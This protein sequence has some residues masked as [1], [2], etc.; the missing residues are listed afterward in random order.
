MAITPNT[1]LK[2]IKSK[3]AIDNVNQLTFPNKQA[4]YNYFNSLP[5]ISIE[6][7]EV[8]YQRKDNV[9]HFPGHIDTL[10]EYNYCMYQNENYEN[11]WFYAYIVRMEYINDG[12]TDIYLSTDVWQTWQFDLVFKES[13]VEREMINVNED[14]AGANLINEDIETGEYI[15]EENIQITDLD[16]IVVVAYSGDKLYLGD[17]EVD[18]Q[19]TPIEEKIIQKAYSINGIPSSI[20][21]FLVENRSPGLDN[22]FEYLNLKNNSDYIITAFTVPRL[23]VSEFLIDENLITISQLSH[24]SK[25]WLLQGDETLGTKYYNQTPKTLNLGITPTSLDGYT[26]RNKKLLQY[27]F[28]YLGF[29]ASSGSKQIYRYENFSSNEKQFKV[30]SEVNPN[31][32][33]LFIPQNYKGISND[34]MQDIACLTGYPT[35][36]YKNDVFNSWIAQ[37]S[38]ILTLQRQ[39][40]EF[41]YKMDVAS[42]GMGIVGD[43]LRL[44]SGDPSSMVSGFN[45]FIENGMNL[46]KD[47][48]KMNFYIKQQMA[49]IEKQKML[50]DNVNLGSSN[51]TLIGYDLNNKDCFSIYSIKRQFAERIDKYFDMY[52]YATNKV[53]IPNINNR[54]NWNYIKT[55]GINIIGNI[56]QN[57]LQLIK[58]M[59]NNGFTVW[60]NP[61]TFLDYSQNNR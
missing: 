23:S 16:E 30:Y 3:L 37:N 47:D 42:H 24:I 46:T 10:L 12:L 29:K 33:I 39:E 22:L 19:V 21:Y 54:T 17:I 4:Q 25:I 35:I 2:L 49:Q 1:N 13:F 45:G 36:S 18:G 52:G 59:F 50:P 43:T 48:A 7:E 44:L 38:Q 51:A 58:N 28:C 27:P 57:D 9:L 41:N 14:V 61:N 11:K 26:P 5:F 40:Q 8:S 6:D 34:S 55:L 15:A 20:A 60:H 53:K 32:S 31:P 56:P